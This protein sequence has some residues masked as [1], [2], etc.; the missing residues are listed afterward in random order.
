NHADDPVVPKQ[1]DLPPLTHP[2]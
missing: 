1:S 2:V